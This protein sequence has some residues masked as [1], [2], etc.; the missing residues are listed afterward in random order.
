MTIAERDPKTLAT[1]SKEMFHGMPHLGVMLDTWLSRSVDYKSLDKPG[2]ILRGA[3]GNVAGRYRK[4][5]MN[6]SEQGDFIGDARYVVLRVAELA[7]K[8]TLHANEYGAQDAA[9]EAIQGNI[10]AI[11]SMVI[12]DESQSRA[13][14]ATAYL[15]FGYLASKET[16]SKPVK[17][18][19]MEAI[20]RGSQLLAEEVRERRESH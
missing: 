14:K 17:K 19:A 5:E 15:I 4:H 8:E 18:V 11:E 13:L 16:Y 20:R 9:T 12:L 3:L 10:M 2:R 7:Y 1:T 6:K